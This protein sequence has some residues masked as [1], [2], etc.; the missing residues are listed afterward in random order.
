[1]KLSYKKI[2][3]RNTF[4]SFV[5]ITVFLFN[6]IHAIPQVINDLLKPEITSSEERLLSWDQHIKMEEES[7][8][9][10]LK[11]RNSG[12][13]FIGGRISS[14]AVPRGD[15]FTIY[16]SAGS[17]GIWKTINNGTTWKSIFNNYPTSAIGDIEVAP[18]DPNIIWAGT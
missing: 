14:I 11:W 13:V 6:S 9:K 8:F 10:Y 12:P 7:S 17:G 3:F 16:I 5:F 1:M 4:S 2:C 18:S 15:N